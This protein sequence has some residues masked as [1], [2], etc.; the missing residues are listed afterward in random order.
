MNRTKEVLMKKEMMKEG[1]QMVRQEEE[2]CKKKPEKNKFLIK[3]MA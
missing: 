3:K 1:L 2:D